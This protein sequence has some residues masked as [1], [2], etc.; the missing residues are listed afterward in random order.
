MSDVQLRALR[1]VQFNWALMEEDVWEPSPF[2]VDGLHDGVKHDV[3]GAIDSAG[4]S[5]GPNPIGLVFEGEKGAGKTHMLGWARE[6]VQ[7]RDGYFFL[8]GLHEG[9]SFW[10]NVLLGVLDGLLRPTPSG[11]DQIQ[12]FLRR[13]AAGVGVGRDVAAAVTGDAPL[14][15]TALDA[16]GATLQQRHGR[17][18]RQHYDVM[19]ALAL[20]A[21]RDHTASQVGD[22]FLNG[23]D[24]TNPAQ[25]S[26]WG[27]RQRPKTPELVV[28]GIFQL[29]ALTGPSI[30]AVDQID[31]LFAASAARAGRAGDDAEARVV[32]DGVATGLMALHQATRRTVTIVACLSGTWDAIRASA[33]DTVPARFREARRLRPLPSPEVATDLVARRLAAIY[34][35][36]GFTPP[37]PTWPVAPEAFADA[38][39]YMPRSLL[40]RID[41][42]IQSCL[43]LGRVDD[44]T[45]LD[46]PVDPRPRLPPGP[47]P[48]DDRLAALDERFAG[49][50]DRADIGA[51]LDFR[52]EDDVMPGLLK[53]GLEAWVKERGAGAGAFSL[54]PPPGRRPAL[55]ARLRRTLDEAVEDEAHWSFR[56][57]AA[58]NAI[59]A[60]TRVAKACTASG[61]LDGTGRRQLCLLRTTAW[62]SG[63]RTQQE[64][65]AFRQA[66]G[67]D[68]A[69]TEHDLRTFSALGAMLREGD[70]HLG[71]WLVSRQPATRS[72]LF[73]RV[74]AKAA[75][76]LP[77]P[78]PA[79]PPA[80]L[81]AETA[82]PA[83]AQG[84]E[85]A[86][87]P[88]P[89][90]VVR[91]AGSVV[92]GVGT[93]GQA[94][95][96]ALRDLT[97]HMVMFAGSGSG[98]TV[99]IR[100][101]IEEC[102]LVGVSTIVL[103][104]NNDLARLGDPWPEPPEGWT[105]GDEE[106]SRQYLAATD[107]VVWTPNR[108]G[109]RPLTFQPLPDFRPVL[110]D[111]D[112]FN[113]A[114]DAALAALAPRAKADGTAV[115]AI[116]QRAV[117]RQ[118]LEAFARA[119]GGSLS[120][121]LQM[122]A[123]LPDGTCDLDD[124]AKVAAG[125]AQTLRAV[126]IVDPLFGGIGQSADPG[127]LLRPPPGK[128]ARVSV[129]NFVGLADEAARQGFVNQLQMAL[130]AWVK[131]N[132][133]DGLGG[134]L[135]MDEA[136]TLAPSG[137][138][139]ACTQS[140]LVLA[141]QARKYGLGLLFATQAV[142][143][144]HNR[145][146]SNAATQV[147][148][149]MNAP[150]QITAAR[151]LAQAKGGDVPDIS[152]LGHGTFYV[153]LEGRAYAKAHTP[154]CLS[155][156]PSSPLTTEEVVAR[157]SGT[158]G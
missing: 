69:V 41:R 114:V 138:M 65:Q 40:Q 120:A 79:P 122:L 98:K 127:V 34:G 48:V 89:Q 8:V 46:A 12:V 102:A 55:H 96:L 83:Q 37:Y 141:S 156:H 27:L 57:I 39:R 49:L 101:I 19:R 144:L 20:Y 85:V 72:D 108:A 124:A 70:P 26:L 136:Q 14:T 103:D 97:K 130:F 7:R 63:P 50:V 153:A 28:R 95:R 115:K 38:P 152:R 15:T 111:P 128:R 62:P 94:L 61:L 3:T 2:H 35:H 22:S 11:E 71:D 92:L 125:M 23:V 56:A 5:N 60:Q 86:A 17:V 147:L 133:T 67:D 110:D 142:T 126:R 52:T 29:L 75:V 87:P 157:A 64:L 1:E 131:Q 107:V 150:A 24:D 143:G 93:D 119:G 88:A 84:T 116:Q 158:T 6:Q 73:D 140:S 80:P 77:D 155:H 91:D 99:L 43:A 25:H 123:D 137:A 118:A 53:S 32:I 90:P 139:T 149:R 105:P 154:M 68:R 4:R 13:L 44:L 145:I 81:P 36:L 10:D 82:A 148:G 74:L 51:A 134:L 47:G 31:G 18:G 106:R 151:G 129:V 59:A 33:F 117:L 42:H 146:A 121:F 45:R 113:Q 100:R 54:D 104:P 78:A 9:T 109:G 66:G 76:G 132:P 58:G 16:F 112:E 135:V 30:V 21:S